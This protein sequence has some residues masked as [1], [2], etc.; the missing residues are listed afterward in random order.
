MAKKNGIEYA[1]GLTDEEQ[2][3]AD[4]LLREMRQAEPAKAP[5]GL[6]A[7]MQ[8]EFDTAMAVERDT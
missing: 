4:R 6:K 1:E 3:E 5:P 8:N 2:A 7:R